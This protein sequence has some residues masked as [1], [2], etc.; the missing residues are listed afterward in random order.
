MV[1]HFF[2]S[3]ELFTP[4]ASMR[5]QPSISRP[6]ISKR[7]ACGLA[8]RDSVREGSTRNSSP[9]LPLA[10]TAMLPFTKNASPPNMAFSVTPDSPCRHSRSRF[11][12]TS[13]YAM[14]SI[15]YD[16]AMTTADRVPEPGADD[17]AG[18]LR[19]WLAFHRDALAA[20]CDGLSDAQ[21]VEQS[22]PPSSL[23]LLGLVRHL[24]EMER[25][26]LGNSIS[27]EQLPLYYVTDEDEEADIE[28]LDVS[29]VASSMG[30]W[31][32]EMQRTDKI[33]DQHPSFDDR[34]AS[35]KRAIRWCVVKVLQEYARHNGHADIVRERI[36][37]LRGE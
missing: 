20:K 32:A 31:R 28:N 36:D 8:T 24:S 15:I 17:E 13:S 7:R 23:S 19:G 21:L 34:T 29:M 1:T 9:P 30:S 11:A 4:S 27:G 33:L 5:N 35:G 2:R 10:L 37:G 18:L 14:S 26:Y 3:R 22:A 16:L 6:R 12:S 25:H